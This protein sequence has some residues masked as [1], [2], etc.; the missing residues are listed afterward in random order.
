MMLTVWA[1]ILEE[2]TFRAY[3]R[4]SDFARMLLFAFLEPFGYRQLTV[5]WRL[6]S[7]WSVLRGRTQWGEMRRTGFQDVQDK[8]A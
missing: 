7:F 6:R 3:A 5:A 2:V 4:T 8:A 1:V